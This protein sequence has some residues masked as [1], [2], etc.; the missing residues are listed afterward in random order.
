VRGKAV[1]GAWLFTTCRHENP[2]EED[3]QVEVPGDVH[4]KVQHLEGPVVLESVKCR[5]GG[6]ELC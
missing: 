5:D 6:L 2:E 1:F 3:C 4:K